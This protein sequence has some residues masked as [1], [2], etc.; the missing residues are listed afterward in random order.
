VRLSGEMVGQNTVKNKH[1]VPAY[2]FFVPIKKLQ[3]EN[4][5][6]NININSQLLIF[7]FMYPILGRLYY[8]LGQTL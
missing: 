5:K 3:W 6:N 4:Q 2:H 1:A 7:Q 8:L